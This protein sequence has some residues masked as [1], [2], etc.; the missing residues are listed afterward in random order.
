MHRKKGYFTFDTME[1][2]AVTSGS[3]EELGP[4]IGS[5]V[6]EDLNSSRVLLEFLLEATL[7]TT[8]E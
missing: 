4:A 1:V 5:G 2:G 7:E 6:S 3:L 8:K